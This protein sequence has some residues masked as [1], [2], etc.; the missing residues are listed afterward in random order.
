MA[1]K[2]ILD[3]RKESTVCLQVRKIVFGVYVHDA[4]GSIVA[5]VGPRE[6]SEVFVF[7]VRKIQNVLALADLGGVY[8]SLCRIAKI[9]V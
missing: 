3:F 7:Q 5:G 9:Y 6:N 2:E 1:A 4:N 8:R